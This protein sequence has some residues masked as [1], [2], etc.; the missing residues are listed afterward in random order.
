V[1]NLENDTSLTHRTQIYSKRASQDADSKP[2]C[3]GSLTPVIEKRKGSAWPEDEMS[4]T[5][6]FFNKNKSK[7]VVGFS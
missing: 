2:V 1:A 6:N 4:P 5:P 7:T 3:D